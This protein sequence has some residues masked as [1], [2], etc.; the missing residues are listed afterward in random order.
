MAK[1]NDWQE[2]LWSCLLS[3]GVTIALSR[4]ESAS[5]FTSDIHYSMGPMM[6]ILG[7]SCFSF[8]SL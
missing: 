2:Q 7:I 5:E 4:R 8:D 1:C 6:S 3:H